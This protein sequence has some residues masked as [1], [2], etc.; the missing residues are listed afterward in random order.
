MSV[1]S[2]TL[3]D[4]IQKA[5]FRINNFPS[6]IESLT[7]PDEPTQAMI[8]CVNEVLRDIWRYKPFPWMLG[9]AWLQVVAD[10]DPSDYQCTF[11]KGSANVTSLET[12]NSTA[13]SWCN[14]NTQF[15]G[16]GSATNL[17]QYGLINSDSTVTTTSNF[18]RV[19]SIDGATLT[20]EHAWQV[21]TCSD[22]PFKIYYD[23]YPL[24]SDFG[25]FV[26][27]TFADEEGTTP[28]L[29]SLVSPEEMMRRRY[30]LRSAPFTLG[31]PAC[32]TVIGQDANNGYW[33]CQLDPIPTENG[34]LTIHYK[35][36]LSTIS[37]DD[38]A[39]LL[40]D[41]NVSLLINGVVALW[42]SFKGDPQD[43]QRY[44]MWKRTAL[45]EHATIDNRT[46]E[47]AARFSPADTM[48]GPMA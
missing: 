38:D 45:A 35:K 7:T 24:P 34:I 18:V 39:V 22:S 46:T 2:Y 21:T 13:T 44:E 33:L 16:A 9:E 8:E 48:R 5:S 6:K 20:M 12:T 25:D 28:R 30:R 10:Y 23:R 19:S 17:L 3:L 15:G 26:S 41:E 14:L 11:T 40:D 4:V 42:L 31:A 32:A 37:A 43:A 47:S 27:V 29:I 36:R 1:H